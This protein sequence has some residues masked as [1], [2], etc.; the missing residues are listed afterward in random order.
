MTLVT[1]LCL[2]LSFYYWDSVAPDRVRDMAVNPTTQVSAR[3]KA[4]P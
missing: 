2:V 3:A 4:A 1:A